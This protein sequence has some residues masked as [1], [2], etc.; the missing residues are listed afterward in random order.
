MFSLLVR[1]QVAVQVSL[2]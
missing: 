2:D 1:E